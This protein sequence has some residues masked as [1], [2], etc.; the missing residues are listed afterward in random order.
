[1]S[2]AVDLSGEWTGVYN[3]PFA[4]PPV[5]FEAVLLD[6][7]GRISGTTSEMGGTPFSPKRRLDAVID[8]SRNGR[9]VQFIKMYDQ[10]DG[11]YDVVQYEGTIDPDGDEIGGRWVVSGMT[12]T[13]L[14]V[15]QS[16]AKEMAKLAI[17][18]KIDS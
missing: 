6:G 15:R 11:E 1:M 16:K 9:S 7:N 3:Y 2:D 13:F 17:E 8:G 5:A 18:E 10:A 4:L 12:G 14:M